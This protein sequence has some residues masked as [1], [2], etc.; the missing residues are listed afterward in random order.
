MPCSAA[1]GEHQGSAE[2]F[3]WHIELSQQT[4]QAQSM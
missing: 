3:W 4:M 2:A 1:A